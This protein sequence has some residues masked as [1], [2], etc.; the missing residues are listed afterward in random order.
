MNSH[1][2]K[3]SRSL[4]IFLCLVLTGLGFDTGCVELGIIPPPD[5]G[6][7]PPDGGDGDGG[8]NGGGDD[9]V[10]RVRLAV[11]NLTPQVN[12]EVTLRCVL[13]NNPTGVIVF[14]FQA[15]G[16][17]TGR[18]VEDPDRGTASLIVQEPDIG[19]AVS[20]TC[21]AANELG[22]GPRST[23]QIVVATSP[24]PPVPLP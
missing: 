14:D 23:P 7:G 11:S 24:E 10:P 17:P 16:G 9:V 22:E 13:T 4:M 18:L 19:V 12:E 20:V 21:S 15:G 1:D 2:K 8:G 6:S 5:D 3:V